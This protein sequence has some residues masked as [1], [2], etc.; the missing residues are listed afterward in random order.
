[1][2]QKLN[3]IVEII[4]KFGLWLSFLCVMQK[5]GE[6]CT[7]LYFQIIRTQRAEQQA[8]QCTQIAKRA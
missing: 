3:K 7:I 2:I 4:K 6:N 8:Q 5:I 1:M